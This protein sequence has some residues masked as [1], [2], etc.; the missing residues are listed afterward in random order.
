MPYLEATVMETLRFANLVPFSAPHSNNR[1]V[2]FRGYV[3][4]KGAFIL[5]NMET[6][7]HDPAEWGDPENFRPERFIGPDG[8][9]QRPDAYIPFGN[10]TTDQF[11]DWLIDYVVQ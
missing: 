11:S 4:P 5:P 3:I 9:L 7:L 1:D 2:S 10:G 6:V 8:K